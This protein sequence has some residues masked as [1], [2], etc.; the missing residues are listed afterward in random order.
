MRGV[1]PV[2]QPAAQ[3]SLDDTGLLVDLLVHEVRVTVGLVAGGV[4]LDHRGLLRGAPGV[5]RRGPEPVGPEG[6]DLAVVQ[7]HDLPGVPDQRRYVGGSEHLLVADAEQDRAAVTGD[8]QLVGG[9]GVDARRDRRCRRLTSGPAGPLLPGRAACASV[10]GTAPA[11]AAIRCAKISL[12]V[13]EA[14][15]AP[16]AIRL[17]PQFLGVLDDPVVNDGDR[18]AGVRVRVLVAR[19]AVRRP[20]RM[21]DARTPL[22]LRGHVGGELGY[23]SLGL[24]HAQV[25]APAD[26]RDPG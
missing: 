4:R 14:N 24:P 11:W 3:H 20:P 8:D 5:E 13:C 21:T 10:P 6:G 1:E 17:G 2:V 25:A 18:T 12:S 15:C 9:A 19:L 16:S 26:D 23:A 22:D 7:V